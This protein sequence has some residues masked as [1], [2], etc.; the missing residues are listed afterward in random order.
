LV[1]LIIFD[2]PLATLT[3][4]ISELQ[5]HKGAVKQLM[6]F[7]GKETVFLFDAEMGS[8]KT[9]FIKAIC[10]YLGVTDTMSSPTFS[11]VNEYKTPVNKI[12][13]F[14][15]Y[16][17]KNLKELYEIGFE[18]YLQGKNYVFIEW[19]TLALTFIDSYIEIKIEMK[20]NNRY[21]R[22]QILRNYE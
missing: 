12:F 3:I 5:M 8:G 17:I 14:D 13:H 2:L 16:R 18:E 20:G 21:L 10:I 4:D 1:F 22:A 7:C 11:I 15:L 9:T 6:E 19:P